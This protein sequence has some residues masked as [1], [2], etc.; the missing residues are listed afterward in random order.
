MFKLVALMGAACA[1]GFAQANTLPRP[2]C[3]DDEVQA[4]AKQIHN[5]NASIKY[6]AKM[7]N[8]QIWPNRFTR[9]TLTKSGRLRRY[10]RAGVLSQSIKV[11]MAE[12]ESLVRQ[13]TACQPGT[14][15]AIPALDLPENFKNNMFAAGLFARPD[16]EFEIITKDPFK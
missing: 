15:A 2:G 7:L 3:S 13:I 9:L 14:A 11:S 6:E 4:I 16:V 5:L 10:M 12:R 8:G 1:F